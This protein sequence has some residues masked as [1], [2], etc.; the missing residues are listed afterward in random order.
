MIVNSILNLKN[1]SIYR[2]FHGKIKKN[3]IIIYNHT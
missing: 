2:Y 1:Y 3:K